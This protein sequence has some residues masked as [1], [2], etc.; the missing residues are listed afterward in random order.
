MLTARHMSGMPAGDY[1]DMQLSAFK[2][3][4]NCFVVFGVV[5]QAWKKDNCSLCL[6]FSIDIQPPVLP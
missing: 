2:S 3:L 6:G 5:S 4:S 1:L